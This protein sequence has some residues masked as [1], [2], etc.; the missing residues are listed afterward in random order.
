MAARL[1]FDLI[2]DIGAEKLNELKSKTGVL[3]TNK[4]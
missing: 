4:V 2:M 3:I 1:M